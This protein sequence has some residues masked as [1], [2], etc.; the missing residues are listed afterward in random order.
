MSDEGGDPACWL[1]NV[2]AECG[3]LIEGRMPQACPRCGSPLDE[4]GPSGSTPV[5]E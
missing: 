2:C 4:T 3:L 1:A 5:A